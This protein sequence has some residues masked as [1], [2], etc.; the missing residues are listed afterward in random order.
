MTEAQVAKKTKKPKK[1]K[2]IEVAANPKIKSTRLSAEERKTIA[3][4]VA[5]LKG[6][7]G[8]D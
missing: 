8:P 5:A 7:V 1:T 2:K 6:K 3:A 4:I